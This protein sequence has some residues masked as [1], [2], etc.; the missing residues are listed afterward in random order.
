MTRPT[1][2][3]VTYATQDQT[4]TRE[5]PFS[6]VRTRPPPRAAAPQANQADIFT[7]VASRGTSLHGVPSRIAPRTSP[8]ACRRSRH[9]RRWYR[10]RRDRTSGRRRLQW[11]LPAKPTGQDPVREPSTGCGATQRRKNTNAWLTGRGAH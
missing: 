1:A 4:M 8:N 9:G 3:K 10:G 7:T 11:F 6:P 5:R 2:I